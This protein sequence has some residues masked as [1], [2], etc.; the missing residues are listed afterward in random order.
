MVK[1][2]MMV[3]KLEIFITNGFKKRNGSATEKQVMICLFTANLKVQ[4]EKGKSLYYCNLKKR[5]CNSK[6]FQLFS[7]ISVLILYLL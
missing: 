6:I 4:L 5:L 2:E 1:P 7:K 3:V